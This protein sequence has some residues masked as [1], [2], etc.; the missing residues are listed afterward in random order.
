MATVLPTLAVVGGLFGPP[1]PTSSDAISLFPSNTDRLE[2][3]WIASPPACESNTTH[4]LPELCE[5]DWSSDLWVQTSNTTQD[6]TRRAWDSTPLLNAV[7][8]TEWTTVPTIG[9]APE[10]MKPLQQPLDDS[11]RGIPHGQPD[12][13]YAWV[14]SRTEIEPRMKEATSDSG[15]KQRGDNANH[16]NKGQES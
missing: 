5:E 6:R 7:P 1:L 3:E 2:S 11:Q 10:G 12:D 4:L 14:R 13:Q 9:P 8:P 15:E 16:R